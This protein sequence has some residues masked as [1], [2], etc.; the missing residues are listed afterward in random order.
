MYNNTPPKPSQRT[1]PK[2]VKAPQG[3]IDIWRVSHRDANDRWTVVGIFKIED[4][5]YKAADYHWDR[6]G[7]H[8]RRS[9]SVDHKAAIEVNKKFYVVNILPFKFTE[10]PPLVEYAPH[11][12]DGDIPF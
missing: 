11:Q 5:A 2:W 8:L 4:A 3:L 9:V 1:R 6:L 7:I 10:P 12:S